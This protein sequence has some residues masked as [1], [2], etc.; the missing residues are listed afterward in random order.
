MLQRDIPGKNFKLER[1]VPSNFLGEMSFVFDSVTVLL[2]TAT[3]L[4][5]WLLPKRMVETAASLFK[6]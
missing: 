2:P 1:A 4:E 3:R 6:L 5:V